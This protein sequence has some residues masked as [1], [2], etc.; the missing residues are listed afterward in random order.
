MSSRLP[1]LRFLAFYQVME[2][3]FDA[4]SNERL[5]DKISG[6]IKDP[7]FHASTEQLVHMIR[8]V[9]SFSRENNETNKLKNVLQKF[10]DEK[11]LIEFISSYERHLSDVGEGK[12]YSKIHNVF[13]KDITVR[14]EEGQCISNL[15][16][17]IK[18][19]RNALV[20]SSDGYEG[21]V[22][23][24]P[25]TETTKKI[26]LDIPLMKFLAEKVIIASSISVIQKTEIGS[27]QQ[28]LFPVHV[29]SS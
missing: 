1:E 15:A 24:V 6:Q 29:D 18:E 11:E 21:N 10:V 20:H 14:L 12:V 23:H 3:F 16:S 8:T 13:G 2:Y 17:H 22:R 28:P 5:C 19:T 7:K 27:T 26:L 25:F 4:V 9:D